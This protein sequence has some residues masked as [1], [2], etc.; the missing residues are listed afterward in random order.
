LNF[1]IILDILLREVVGRNPG[2]SGYFG[3]PKAHFYSVE[4]QSRKTLHVHMLIWLHDDPLLVNMIEN[5][6]N[7]RIQKALLLKSAS[8][9]DKT[10]SCFINGD[11][12]LGLKCECSLTSERVDP[13]IQ[14]NQMLRNLRHE[15]AGC[16][17]LEGGGVAFC[18][19]CDKRWTS[20]EL[21]YNSGF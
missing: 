5:A 2:L 21:S 9:I 18:P 6:V 12:V 7:K 16:R 11:E 19:K 1:E 15:E 3:K 4:E 20:S 17:V 8:Y 10:Q 13:E 14:S